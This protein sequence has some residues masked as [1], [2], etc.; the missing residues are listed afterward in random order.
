MRLQ[1]GGADLTCVRS[2]V[3][4]LAPPVYP[5]GYLRRV[6]HVGG[7]A[8]RG[9][10]CGLGNG[11]VVDLTE[12][13]L[14]NYDVTRVNPTEQ[15]LGNYNAA[16]VDPT[17]HELGNCNAARVDPTEHELGNY[18][19]SRVDPTEYELGNCN[20]ARVDPTEHE[21][22]NYDVS[23]VDPTEYELENCDVARVDPTEQGLGNC[24]VGLSP[25]M[26]SG[27]NMEIWPRGRSRAQIQRFGREGDLERKFGDFG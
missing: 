19:V 15:E 26:K 21:L 22:G 18:D 8:V 2:A 23:R 5:G 16:R 9:S 6:G 3:R 24:N 11:A 1:V 14:G 25:R 20:A 10:E 12:Q 7:P 13:E 17:E 4:R 27:A